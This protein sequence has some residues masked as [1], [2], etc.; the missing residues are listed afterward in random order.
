[1]TQLPRPAE[2]EHRYLQ[3]GIGRSSV[4]HSDWSDVTQ[5]HVANISLCF[6]RLGKKTDE[7][8]MKFPPASEFNASA[9][10]MAH[11]TQT[12]APATTKMVSQTGS[13]SRALVGDSNR[14]DLL[15]SERMN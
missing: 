1:M 7:G 8:S 15:S 11:E 10:T 3:D 14:E 9:G 13:E 6:R 2:F 4:G 5:Y 12:L